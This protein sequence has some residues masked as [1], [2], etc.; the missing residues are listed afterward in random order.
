MRGSSSNPTEL[1]QASLRCVLKS[2]VEEDVSALQP[3][4]RRRM[5]QRQKFINN[6]AQ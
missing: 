4:A 5:D 1:V 6:V 3:Q 2:E